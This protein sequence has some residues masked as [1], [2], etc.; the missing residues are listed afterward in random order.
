MRGENIVNPETTML[1]MLTH[2]IKMP[3]SVILS[4]NDII[5]ANSRNPEKV[6]K[7]SGVI[8]SNVYRLIRFSEIMYGIDRAQLGNVTLEQ[9]PLER[10][11]KDTVKD[12]NE[13]ITGT[14]RK[15]TRLNSSH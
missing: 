14:D 2:D 11:T 13:L 7:Y 5:A 6:A 4:A 15:S 10:I 8:K 12:T 9:V 3:L 1:S